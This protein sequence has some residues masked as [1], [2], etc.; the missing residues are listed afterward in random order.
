MHVIEGLS[1]SHSS[2]T[3][4][5]VW[6]SAERCPAPTW[7]ADWLHGCTV[8]QLQGC[9]AVCMVAWLHGQASCKATCVAGWLDGW[10]A[11]WLRG[12]MAAWLAAWLH[13]CMAARLHGC[14]AAWLHWLH[15]CMAARVHGCTGAWLHGC[16]AAQLNGCTAT[17]L[18]ARHAQT[19]TLLNA[20][21]WTIELPTVGDVHT[22][23]SCILLV[24]RLHQFRGW[25]SCIL[26]VR[27]Y[28]LFAHSTC[29]CILVVRAYYL[30][31]SRVHTTCS[32]LQ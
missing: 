9:I 14:T 2:S 10:M 23:C 21:Y 16:T 28:Y 19:C 3:S 17:L 7:L 11:A 13:G 20:R 12:C 32:C 1:R 25:A 5:A 18:K 22:T 27:A 6:T 31:G 4:V 24:S 26:L 15:G 30:F 29:S 8:A